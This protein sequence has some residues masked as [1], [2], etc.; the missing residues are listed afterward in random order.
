MQDSQPS[1][2][3]SEEDTDMIDE[4]MLGSDIEET[5]DQE[6]EN[7][8]IGV[9]IPHYRITTHILS[10][11]PW[12]HRL[13]EPFFLEL[14]GDLTSI[15]TIGFGKYT[16]TIRSTQRITFWQL[17]YTKVGSPKLMNQRQHQIKLTEGLTICNWLWGAKPHEKGNH[18]QASAGYTCRI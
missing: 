9:S 11:R 12:Y 16:G 7:V 3:V 1:S 15:L 10:M 6:Q 14:A 5:E 4:A 17:T 13:H 18:C 8:R 2:E